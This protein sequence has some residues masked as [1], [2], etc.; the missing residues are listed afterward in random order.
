MTSIAALQASKEGFFYRGMALA[1][2]LTVFAGFAPSFF[3]KNFFGAAPLS[4]LLHAHGLAFSSWYALFFTQAWLA[5]RG[6]VA[7]HKKL[8]VAGA[9]LAAA[10]VVLGVTAG[11]FAIRTNHTPPGLDPRSF[12]VL[13]F[14][15]ITIFAGFVAAAVLLRGRPE[16]HKRLMLL[17]SVAMLDAPIAR[18]PG[19]FAAGGPL[20]TFGLQ[21]LFL[22]AAV[23]CDYRAR[24]RVHPAYLWGGLVLL[25]AQPL[26]IIVAGTPWWL[27]FGDWVKG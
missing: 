8:G 3:L 7:L 4:P 22:L 14:F 18:L 10:M 24:G 12:L 13:P 1:M 25:L 23:L 26:R 15:G 17:A 19:V 2:G 21:D 27:A 20:A 5:G 11:V 9:A 6:E 16:A